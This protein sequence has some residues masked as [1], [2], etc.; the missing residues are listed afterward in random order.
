MAG[1]HHPRCHHAKAVQ[2]RGNRRH[3]RRAHHLD[4]RGAGLSRTWDYRYCWLRDAYFVVKALNRVGATRTME[5]FI[6]FTLSLASN[7]EEDL[8]P[9]YSLVPNLP[10]NEWTAAE[11]QGYRGRL[12]H[13]RI[14]PDRHEIVAQLGGSI[15]A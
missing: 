2:L 15:L 11:L 9:V 8:K 4:S 1:S 12:L 3:Y 7:A 5:D 10:L 6:G 13:G 14:D